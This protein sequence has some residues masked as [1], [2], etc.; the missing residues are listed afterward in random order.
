MGYIF[1]F[2]DAKRYDEWLLNRKNRIAA[3]LESR[4]MMGM[5][6]PAHGESVLDIGCGTGAS[7]LPL[8]ERGLDVTGIDP[9]PY[10]LD[11]MSATLGH[12]VSLYRGYA[13]D[14]PFDDNSFNH[15]CL[16]TALEFVDD[17][18]KAL[19]E[20]FRVAKDRVF[21]GVL[22]RYALTGIGRRVK[23]IFTPTIYNR[24]TFFSVW[25]IKSMARNLLGPVPVRWRTVC[26]FPGPWG[27][28]MKQIEG[29][30]LVQRFPFGTF[31]GMVV[32]LLPRFRTRPLAIRYQPEKVGRIAAGA[33]G[34]SG[35]APSN[36]FTP[37]PCQS[38]GHAEI[39]VF[40]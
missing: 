34:C 3:D 19:E 25:E 32:T 8:L 24:A 14:L 13:E 33:A 31:A 18:Q 37:P 21:I 16:F 20:A 9:S 29:S 4:L 28:W 11:I 15:A 2:H 6:D 17:P 39:A 5:L 1:D 38:T 26:Q 36:G 23:G 10:M 30:G 35:M 40:P 22:N 12:R 27:A 7:S